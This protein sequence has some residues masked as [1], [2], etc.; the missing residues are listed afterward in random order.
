LKEGQKMK[1]M[2]LAA[3]L[4][5]VGAFGVRAQSLVQS[6]DDILFWTGNGTNR[7]A[8]VLQWNDGGSPTSLAWGYRWSGATTGM[9]MLKAIAGSV[10][11]TPGDPLTLLESS[12]GA[13]GRMVLSIQRYGFGDSVLSISI[14]DGLTTRNQADWANGYWAYSIFGGTFSYDNYDADGNYLGPASYSQVGNPSFS[15][16]NW[17]VSP[18]GAS[19][20]EL[21]DGSWD[22]FSFAPGFTTT[23]VAQPFA[24]SVPEPSV[25]I[26]LTIAVFFFMLKR[27]RGAPDYTRG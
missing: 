3:L 12:S 1:K 5:V 19:D 20:R 9:D 24:V 18:I 10:T 21:V 16:I 13:D 11:V 27:E 4:L 14:Q 26:L 15:S 17:L 8:L 23:A 6:F 2:V 25:A 22:A 7:S